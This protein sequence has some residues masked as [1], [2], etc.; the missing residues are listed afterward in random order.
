MS[1]FGLCVKCRKHVAFLALRNFLK[2][3]NILPLESA[4]NIAQRLLQAAPDLPAEQV[5]RAQALI[6][7]V[8]KLLARES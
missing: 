7:E 8:E 6:K 2:F 5:A 4:L 3:N 1:A